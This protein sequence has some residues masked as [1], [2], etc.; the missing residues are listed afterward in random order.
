MENF[1]LS[2]FLITRLTVVQDIEVAFRGIETGSLEALLKS[3]SSEY[4]S[5][6]YSSGLEDSA[7]GGELQISEY[8]DK[9]ISLLR[10]LIVLVY[11]IVSPDC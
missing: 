5:R 4:K 10:L 8:A 7:M 1:L 3:A 2:A 9:D 6:P 11:V